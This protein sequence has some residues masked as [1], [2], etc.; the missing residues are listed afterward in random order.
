MKSFGK[1]IVEGGG[2]GHLSH[3]WDA[4]HFTFGDL[5]EIIS[6]ALSGKLEY[7]REKCIDG[8]SIVIV[9]GNP[10]EIRKVVDENIGDYILSYDPDTKI[11]KDS[12]IMGRYNNGE[13]DEW[14]IIE[15]DDGKVLKLTPNHRILTSSGFKKAEELTEED[16]VIC[17]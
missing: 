10:V 8:D 17:F 11:F 1:F 9:D 6:N 3:P 16:E 2:Y 12:L 4:E 13:I 7:T 15:T 14:I 5:K